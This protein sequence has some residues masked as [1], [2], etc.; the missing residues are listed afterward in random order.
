MSIEV[1]DE[2]AISARRDCGPGAL[3]VGLL[4]GGAR[5][6]AGNGDAAGGLGREPAALPPDRSADAPPFEEPTTGRRGCRCSRDWRKVRRRC[7]GAVSQALPA[8]RTRRPGR[9]GDGDDGPR[10]GLSHRAHRDADAGGRQPRRGSERRPMRRWR[11][12]A[13]RARGAG[14]P[15]QPQ[16][17]AHASRPRRRPRHAAPPCGA[18]ASFTCARRVRERDPFAGGVSAACRS[19]RDARA[20]RASRRRRWRR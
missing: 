6:H 17:A 7:V 13:G 16:P 14:S 8:A 3:G 9:A 4:P 5:R 1:L 19:R 15:G 10:Q 12:P 11:T 2:R 20:D 18:V